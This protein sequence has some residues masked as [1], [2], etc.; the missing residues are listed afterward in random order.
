M[1]PPNTIPN[2]ITP[3]LIPGNHVNNKPPTIN[4][5]A[6]IAIILPNSFPLFS[7]ILSEPCIAINGATVINIKTLTL[8]ANA[9]KSPIDTD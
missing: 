6:D 7:A 2:S 8:N 4:V 5:A 9:N 1:N 3:G